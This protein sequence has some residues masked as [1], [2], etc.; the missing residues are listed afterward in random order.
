MQDLRLIGVHEDGEHLLLA[1][2]DGT[3]FRVRIDEP[4]RAAVRRDRPRLGQL[5]I[6]VDGGLRPRDVQ[7]LIR[8]GASVE[9]VA[10][11]AGWPVEKVRR[12]EGPVIAEREHVAGLARE[13]RLRGRG[14]SAGASAPT[15]ATRVS[16]RLSGRG[17]DPTDATWDS[18]RS[19]EG[20]WTVVL[21]FP[22]GGRQRQASWTYHSTDRTVTAVDDE[23]RWLSE[24]EQPGVPGPIPAPHLASVPVRSTTVYDVE[25]EGGVHAAG[26]PTERTAE[27]LD[28]MTAMRERSAARARRRPGPR[29]DTPP[30]APT[31]SPA[32]PTHV[33]GSADAPEEAVPLEHIAYDPTTMPPPPP[34]HG[35]PGAHAHWDVGDQPGTPAGEP[36]DADAA[37]PEDDAALPEE[38][39]DAVPTVEAVPADED[40]RDEGD[41]PDVEDDAQPG[42]AQKRAAREEAPTRRSASS[43][44]SGRP[45]VPSWDD[46]M[47]GARPGSD[48]G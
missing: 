15:L 14:G 41:H 6:E 36:E 47:F 28:L 35:Y 40:A 17:V 33:P 45:S 22:A 24:D 48:R 43:R 20:P 5:Q 38:V 21:T 30:P 25:A 8:A 42:A 46:I 18:W 16:Q 23:A 11:R 9:E 12:Y 31:A 29:R 13:V 32:T 10:E 4:I 34:A 7:A 27:P 26:R 2:A 3:R 44:R 39:S 37:L 19:D 1:A